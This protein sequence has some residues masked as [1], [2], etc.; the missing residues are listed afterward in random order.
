MNESH[1]NQTTMAPLP[2]PPSE[3]ESHAVAY[4]LIPLGSLA[5]VA[6][7]AFVVRRFILFCLPRN[8]FGLY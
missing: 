1:I 2:L 6:V 7:L 5:L 3:S 8:F 4:V